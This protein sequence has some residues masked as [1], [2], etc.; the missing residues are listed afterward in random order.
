MDILLGNKPEVGIYLDS[1]KE[2]LRIKNSKEKSLL[3]NPSPSINATDDK[4][5]LIK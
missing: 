4:K 1:E 5:F 3:S 2:T